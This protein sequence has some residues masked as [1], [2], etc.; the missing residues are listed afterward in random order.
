MPS[1]SHVPDR[2]AVATLFCCA[3]VLAGCAKSGSRA[4]G[5]GAVADT[6]AAAPAPSATPA[7]VSLADVAGKWKMRSMNLSGGDVLD[8]E[9]TVTPD[10]SDWTVVGP[11]R[12]P[13]R[14]RVVAVAGDSI[15]A[16]AGP[17]ESFLLEG[18]KVTQREVYRLRDGKLVGTLSGVYSTARGDSTTVRR[19]EGT[20]I[21]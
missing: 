13:V 5:E 8:Y 18:V 3:A 7:T 14:I 15:V 16:E 4:A 1:H 10:S 2:A 12:P 19:I 11:N 9:M 20:R 17:Y 21:P 6:G